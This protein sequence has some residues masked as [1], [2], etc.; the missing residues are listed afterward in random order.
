VLS[1][2]S[3]FLKRSWWFKFAKP[4]PIALLVNPWVNFESSRHNY[5]FIGLLFGMMGDIFLL[6]SSKSWFM[7][8]LVSFLIGHLFYS[9][10]FLQAPWKLPHFLL[11]FVIGW[12]VVYAL[13]IGRSLMEKRKGD[14]IFPV[15]I[16][17]FVIHFMFITALNYEWSNAEVPY[18]TLGAFL[19]LISDSIFAF[20]EF[21]VL[22]PMGKTLILATYYAAQGLVARGTLFLTD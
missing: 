2:G 19:F 22:V 7:S 3:I 1:V 18:V 16:Y 15:L 5:V 14:F 4:L 20:N 10:S 17:L 8:G 6:K 9:I 11:I 13:F 12:S 21:I